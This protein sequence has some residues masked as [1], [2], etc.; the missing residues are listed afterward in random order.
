MRKLANQEAEGGERDEDQKG[1]G[2]KRTEK[3]VSDDRSVCRRTWIDGI[4]HQKSDGRG[5][6]IHERQRNITKPQ[7]IRSGACK[8]QTNRYL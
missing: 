7:M 3:N 1:N 2:K 8:S 5:G 6:R 4:K